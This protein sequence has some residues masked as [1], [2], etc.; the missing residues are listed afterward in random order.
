MLRHAH[1][2]PDVAAVP[3]QH[4]QG[5]RDV[6]QVDVVDVRLQREERAAGEGLHPVG[7]QGAMLSH[8]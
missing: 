5:V 6:H 2:G 1:E 8:G 7:A 3:A 4:R